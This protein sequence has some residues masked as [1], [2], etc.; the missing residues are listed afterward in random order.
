MTRAKLL[1]SKS[2]IIA[3]IQIVIVA[4]DQNGLLKISKDK[5]VVID[6]LTKH[7]GLNG[8]RPN[9]YQM[10]SRGFS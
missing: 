9:T 7:R 6:A 8:I 4:L 2:E 10:S 5:L 1:N 3:E